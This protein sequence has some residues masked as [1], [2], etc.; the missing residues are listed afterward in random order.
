MPVLLYNFGT[1]HK[2][3]SA[4][5][6]RSSSA[7]RIP[8]P[9]TVHATTVP[10]SRRCQRSHARDLTTRCHHTRTDS[11]YSSNSTTTTVVVRPAPQATICWSAASFRARTSGPICPIPSISTP[12]TFSSFVSSQ[13]LAH[14]FSE[15]IY[16]RLYT[17]TIVS[18]L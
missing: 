11:S 15:E 7:A 3:A 5:P 14:T 8:V 16:F 17:T 13:A 1:L 6:P 12:Q 9:R 18:L 2:E 4:T 10:I